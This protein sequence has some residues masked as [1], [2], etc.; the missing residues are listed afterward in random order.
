MKIKLELE[1]DSNEDRDE[2]ES[3]IEFVNEIKAL[4]AQAENHDDYTE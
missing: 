4:V 2:I 1:I 3:I